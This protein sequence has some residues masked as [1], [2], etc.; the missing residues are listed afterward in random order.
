MEKLNHLNAVIVQQKKEWGEIL[1]GFETR[2]KYSIK[3]TQGNEIYLAAE[4]A[5][6]LARFF[7]KMMRPFIVHI[8]S[9]DGSEVMKII[10]PFRFYYHEIE[11]EDNKGKKLGKVIR[12]FSVFKRNFSVF[13]SMDIEQYKIHG[14]FLHPW[15][16]NIRKNGSEVGKISKKWSGLGKEYFADA[17]N[18][19]IEFTPAIE[20]SHR[21]IF[22]GALFLIDMLYFENR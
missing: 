22:L 15:T 6:V 2:N 19:N 14:P 20:A 10:K 13:D 16:F 7:L 18:F 5:S 1:T 11:V 8:M 3:D 17:D 12:D 9:K 4:E 21:G